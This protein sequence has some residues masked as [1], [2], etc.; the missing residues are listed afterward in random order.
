MSMYCKT[1]LAVFGMAFIAT[2]AAVGGS[3]EG[4]V[5]Q[6]TMT[7]SQSKQASTMGEGMLAIPR[8]DP[9]RGR[10]LFAEKGCVVCHAVNGLGGEDARALDAGTMDPLMNPF[11]FAAR[12]WRG[13]EAMIAFQRDEL[14]GQIE[15]DGQELADIIAF[16]H[17][18]KEQAKFSHK[19]IPAKVE[20]LIKHD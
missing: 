7:S 11:E 10:K 8:M 14:G 3:S 15:L 2:S 6:H 12:M 9:V 5:E 19:D 4:D 13:A 1:T 18:H 17:S 16:V 20:Q